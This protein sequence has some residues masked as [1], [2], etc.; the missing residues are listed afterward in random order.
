MAASIRSRMT[1]A[2]CQPRYFTG[3]SPDAIRSGKRLLEEAWHAGAA[4]G[5]ALEARLQ[6]RLIGSPNQIE[7]V[8]AALE[9]RDARFE[10]P[11]D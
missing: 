2:R 5:L 4:D 8:K 1:S 6:G 7:A 11:K 9:K 10:N 3:R